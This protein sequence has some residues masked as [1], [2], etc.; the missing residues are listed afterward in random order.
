MAGN[1]KQRTIFSVRR[2]SRLITCHIPDNPETLTRGMENHYILSP[3]FLDELEEK[4]E[5][6]SKQDWTIINHHQK[7]DTVF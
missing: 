7:Y 3:F 5:S 2:E 4:L 6:L 1:K